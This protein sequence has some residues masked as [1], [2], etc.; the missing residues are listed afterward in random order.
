MNVLKNAGGILISLVRVT[1]NVYYTAIVLKN[2][3]TKKIALSY[4]H[5]TY[6]FNLI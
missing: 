2:H 3:K 1:H 4:F 5:Q 6:K